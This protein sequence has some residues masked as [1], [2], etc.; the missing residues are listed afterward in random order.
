MPPWPSFDSTRYSPTSVPGWSSLSTSS[1]TDGSRGAADGA[2][3]P[4]S[5]R[6]APEGSDKG[7]AISSY[8]T[9][10]ATVNEP[11]HRWTD[12][13]ACG[14][15]ADCGAGAVGYIMYIARERHA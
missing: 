4:A 14:Q 11:G 3:S 7:I 6:P 5:G 12:V 1:S 2:V 13:G 15:P 8:A 9:A 10:P